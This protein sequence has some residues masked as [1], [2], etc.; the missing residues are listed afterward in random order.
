M[1]GVSSRASTN[2]C[3]DID[4]DKAPMRGQFSFKSKLGAWVAI[5]FMLIP[6]QAATAR[7]RVATAG[8]VDSY[9]DRGDDAGLGNLCK[10]YC[11]GQEPNCLG[12][13]GRPREAAF[14]RYGLQ[15][16]LRLS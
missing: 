3:S 5:A 4:P 12:G 6:L 16:F 14:A 15:R 10:T 1:G 8:A 13:Q 2:T 9:N 11:A 7:M